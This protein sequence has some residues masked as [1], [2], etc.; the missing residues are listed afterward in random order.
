MRMHGLC[1]VLLFSSFSALAD[2][3][4]QKLKVDFQ[5]TML[6]PHVLEQ[7]NSNTIMVASPEWQTMS[8]DRS[9]ILQG[10]LQPIDAKSASF[11]FQ[12]L[13]AETK[14]V[15]SKT[16]L[17]GTY[18]EESALRNESKDKKGNS[19]STFEVKIKPT[20]VVE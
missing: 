20:V 10:R 14:K 3:A 5:V 8:S 6:R 9:L 16:Q 2:M 15:L 12:L 18:G 11:E 1:A 17:A 19:V 7:I 4:P 13:D